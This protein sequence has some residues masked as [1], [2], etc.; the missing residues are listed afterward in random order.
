[1]EQGA[2]LSIRSKNIIEDKPQCSTPIKETQHR[3]KKKY[4]NEHKKCDRGRKD[5]WAVHQ[6]RRR[7]PGSG[8]EAKDEWLTSCL[9]KN[10]E[11]CDA[12]TT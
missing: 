8:I 5:L 7:G 12:P 11:R 6:L 10:R 3:A 1:M 2:F 4:G 9:R